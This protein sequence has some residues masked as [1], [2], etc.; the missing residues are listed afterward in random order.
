MTADAHTAHA[1]GDALFSLGLD[2]INKAAGFIILFACGV[3]TLNAGLLALGHASGQSFGMWLAVTQPRSKVSLDRIQLEFGRL[4]AFSLLV[5][6]AADVIETL[7]HPLHDLSM[8]TLQKMLLMGVLRTGLAYFL[9]KEVEHLAHHAAH[10]DGHHADEHG[11]HE[12]EAEAPSGKGKKES[13]K[14]K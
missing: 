1:H 5:L 10:D 6:V 8:E 4:V 13:K 2:M 7:V 3:A 14:N 9:A 11:A 12:A